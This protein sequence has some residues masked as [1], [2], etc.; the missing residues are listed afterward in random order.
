MT[1]VSPHDQGG[2]APLQPLAYMLVPVLN[3]R[4]DPRDQ[5]FQHPELIPPRWGEDCGI[6]GKQAFVYRFLH[7]ILTEQLATWE[8]GFRFE[9]QI[10]PAKT[11][12][13]GPRWP[14]W[15]RHL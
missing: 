14:G 12:N 7:F 5:L 10:L 2:M 13:L 3:G 8:F 4:L 11:G 6:V 9:L 1:S 15:R